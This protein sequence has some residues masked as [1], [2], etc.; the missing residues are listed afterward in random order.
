MLMVELD[1]DDCLE[2][3]GLLAPGDSRPLA[4]GFVPAAVEAAP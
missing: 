2:R 1:T 3:C 4:Q